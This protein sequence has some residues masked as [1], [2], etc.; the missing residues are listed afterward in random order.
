VVADDWVAAELIGAAG[1]AAG[2]LLTR[3]DLETIRPSLVRCDDGTIEPSGIVR[4]P[5]SASAERE[6]PVT[7]VVAAADGW[8]LAAIACYESPGEGLDV[9]ELGITL[10]FVAEPVRRGKTRVRPG[11]ARPA[12]APMALRMTGGIVDVV[13]GVAM[14]KDAEALL[15]SLT[16]KLGERAPSAGAL[17]VPTDASLVV[18]TRSKE[19][20][21]VVSSA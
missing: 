5:W 13:L 17:S 10:P 7:Q 12:A 9:G 11:V 14:T 21:R 4:V 18:L 20:V 19:S 6:A 1:R 16:A 8:G 3:D 2:G 15:E